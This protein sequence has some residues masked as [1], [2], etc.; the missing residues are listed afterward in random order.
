MD[1]I[2]S[3][4]A[5]RFPTSLRRYAEAL[6]IFP[7]GVTH[8]SRALKPFPIYISRAEGAHKWDLDGNEFVD[9]WIGHGALLLGHNHPAVVRAVSE[10]LAR[11]THYGASHELEIGWGRWVQKLVPSAERVRFVSSGTEATLMAIRLA[12][13]FTRKS[14][15]LRFEGHFHGWHDTAMLGYQPP[16]DTPDSVGIPTETLNR[17]KP[18]PP[19]DISMVEKAL[20][21]GPDV[22]AIILEPAGGANAAIPTR[23]GFLKA[24]REL[25]TARKV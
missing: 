10:Q 3:E 2:H 12:R 17:V 4:F 18:L 19:N 11:G 22:A 16:Y 25:C 13:G 23:P 14:T 9:Y 15:L 7:S 21:G 8:D 20:N 6:E 24:L 1:I 5:A